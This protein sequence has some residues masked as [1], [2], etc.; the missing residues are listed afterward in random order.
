MRPG[1][2]VQVPTL[3]AVPATWP[4]EFFPRE[5]SMMHP[6]GVRQ[7]L[8]TMRRIKRSLVEVCLHSQERKRSLKSIV[9]V[10]AYEVGVT[11]ERLQK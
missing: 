1:R 10:F 3:A 9:F 6:L 5:P 4:A 2:R 8:Y 7:G 11:T